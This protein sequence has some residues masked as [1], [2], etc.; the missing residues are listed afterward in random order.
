[1]T[2]SRKLKTHFLTHEL[3]AFSEKYV[4]NSST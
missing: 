2:A 1:M 3:E 4:Y